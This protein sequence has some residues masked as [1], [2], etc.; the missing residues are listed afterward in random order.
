MLASIAAR[1]FERLVGLSWATIGRPAM[2]KSTATAQI[3]RMLLLP[4]QGLLS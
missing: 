3:S 1:A 4:S 2:S